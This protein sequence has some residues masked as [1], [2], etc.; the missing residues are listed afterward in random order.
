M[1][2]YTVL[3]HALIDLRQPGQDPIHHTTPECETI[4][5]YPMYPVFQFSCSL[6]Q[7]T[8]R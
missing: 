1:F 4:G 3:A 7:S 2:Y 5:F 8:D 6:L